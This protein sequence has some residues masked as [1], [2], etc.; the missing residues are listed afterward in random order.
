MVS[1]MLIDAICD[2]AGYDGEDEDEART[3]KNQDAV[4]LDQETRLSLLVTVDGV[5]R[6]LNGKVDFAIWYESARDGMGT[7]LVAI[8]AK[9]L[10][11]A[12]KGIGALRIT[13]DSIG[14]LDN[15][16]KELDHH[17]HKP[18]SLLFDIQAINP[19]PDW[20]L[21]AAF[22]APQ[23]DLKLGAFKSALPPYQGYKKA[24]DFVIKNLAHMAKVVEEAKVPWIPE[25]HLRDQVRVFDVGELKVLWVDEHVIKDAYND[26]GHLRVLQSFINGSWVVDYSPVIRASTSFVKP[27]LGDLLTSLGALDDSKVHH[28][29]DPSF[30]RLV[31]AKL[32]IYGKPYYILSPLGT[33]C[34]TW[35]RGDQSDLDQRIAAQ[36]R[37]IEQL[38]IVVERVL[39]QSEE[40][41]ARLAVLEHELEPFKD[42]QVKDDDDVASFVFQYLQKKGLTGCWF[43]KGTAR[44]WEEADGHVYWLRNG[45]STTP[46][47]SAATA[48][49]GATDIV[50]ILRKP[51][52]K[53]LTTQGQSSTFFLQHRGMVVVGPGTVACPMLRDQER[54]V[55]FISFRLNAKTRSSKPERECLAAV[56]TLAEV[57]GMVN[58]IIDQGL[59]DDP[60]GDAAIK[61]AKEAKVKRVLQVAEEPDAILEM[62]EKLMAT[63]AND[64]GED[65]EAANNVFSRR[66]QRQSAAHGDMEMSKKQYSVLHWAVQD[67]NIAVVELLLHYGADLQ[68][69]VIWRSENSATLK[70]KRLSGASHP[71]HSSFAKDL[72]LLS[73]QTVAEQRSTIRTKI[74]ASYS[75]KPLGTKLSSGTANP[76]ERLD[77]DELLAV[78]EE[79]RAKKMTRS[80]RSYGGKPVSSKDTSSARKAFQ[81]SLNEAKDRPSYNEDP[82]HATKRPDA[83]PSGNLPSE[84]E[85][86]GRAQDVREALAGHRNRTEIK[87]N[88]PPDVLKSHVQRCIEL[89]DRYT[90][91]R[92]ESAS[93]AWFVGA[94]APKTIDSDVM[95]REEVFRIPAVQSVAFDPN[96]ITRERTEHLLYRDILK[97]KRT[98]SLGGSNDKDWALESCSAPP[99]AFLS[100]IIAINFINQD[101]KLISTLLTSVTYTP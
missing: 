48:P 26:E 82:T 58:A 56:R 32:N 53:P 86:G 80:G 93:Y 12:R 63:R 79:P 45:A 65:E 23:Q 34:G 29:T 59:F 67:G 46:T 78:L 57:K 98:D 27:K 17:S 92:N 75:G 100:P 44:Y 41:S 39:T 77:D 60:Q 47:V 52:E 9:R 20:A 42:I 51:D 49:A 88:L 74:D 31:Y 22:W 89:S 84:S 87:T 5:G 6:N 1:L 62:D 81:Q 91:L 30:R 36:D 3:T 43:P 72:S 61:A 37:R 21:G 50:H 97:R 83:E 70:I 66:R 99:D 54:I 94:K 96:T 14:A 68:H 2:Q 33:D 16:L 40:M 85:R 8:E 55:T 69:R 4:F 95:E 7:N 13:I 25:H 24:P 15:L 10:G 76:T 90:T 18:A 28:G 11:D 64:D 101:S 19:G 38:L 71:T 35:W 73:R